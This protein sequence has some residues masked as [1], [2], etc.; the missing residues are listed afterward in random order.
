M[1][2]KYRPARV[3]KAQPQEGDLGSS[4]NSSNLNKKKLK[5]GLIKL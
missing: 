2:V 4:P 1:V 5:Y 3:G